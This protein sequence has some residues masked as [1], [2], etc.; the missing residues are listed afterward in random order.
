VLE[1]RVRK[2]ILEKIGDFTNVDVTLFRS[3]TVEIQP[4]HLEEFNTAIVEIVHRI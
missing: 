4:E 3:G 2:D 1:I